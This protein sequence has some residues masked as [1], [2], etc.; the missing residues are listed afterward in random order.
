MTSTHTTEA[1]HKN[2]IALITQACEIGELFHTSFEPACRGMDA[3]NL[4]NIVIFL[5]P[6]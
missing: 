5:Y 1:F 6:I 4:Q 3:L 2:S